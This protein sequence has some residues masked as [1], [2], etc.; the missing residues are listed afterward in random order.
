MFLFALLFACG[1]EPAVA[2]APPITDDQIATAAASA[3]CA[4]ATQAGMTC[5]A[6]GARAEL[7]WKA[8]DVTVSDR[9]VMSFEP[10]SMGHGEGAQR[11]PG[12]VQLSATIGIAVD[13]TA[14]LSVPQSHAASDMDL[15]VARDR[16]LEELTERWVVTHA[17]AV[18]DAL[19]GDPGAPVLA[20]LG[21]TVAAQPAGALY[22]WA[23]YPVLRGKGFDPGIANRLGPS[24][25]SVLANLGPYV[26]GLGG[27]GLHTVQV[28]AR[29]GGSGAPGPCGII[30]PVAISPGATTSIVP[31]AG[32]VHVDGQ[33]VGD[34][35]ALSEPV[36]W[37]LPPGGAVLEWDQLAVLAPRQ[38]GGPA[39]QLAP[40]E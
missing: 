27:D 29:L 5:A 3:I 33:P 26:E 24:V 39:V 30:P 31:L 22:A 13:G 12:E 18:V 28:F 2:P 36:S 34:I 35:C 32:E 14:L 25:Q 11:F 40:A 4:A 21:M 37:P 17:S 20:A 15:V 1:S 10:T 38:A 16:V 19:T 9:Q 6:T 23:G 7:G 8:L